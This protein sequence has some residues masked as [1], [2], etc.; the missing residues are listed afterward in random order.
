M[1]L[2]RSRAALDRAWTGEDRQ[3]VTLRDLL[4]HCS[5]LPA[6][7]RYFESR[8][9]PRL[10]RDGH[11]RGAA[12]VS[13]RARSRSTAIPDSCCS[14]SR[15]KM[16]PARRSIGSSMRG[17]I[18]SSGADVELRYRP[19]RRRGCERIAPTEDDAVPA[20]RGRGEV[21]DENA[22]ALGGVAAH[23]GLFGTAAAV[24]ACA[25]WWM[26]SPVAAA[27]RSEDRRVPGSSR[28]LGWDT[29]LPTS[30]C[31]TR[32]RRARS[33]TPASPARRCGSIPRRISMWCF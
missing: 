1:R 9:R 14:A 5:G 24:G 3:A 2:E 23:A 21:H 28:A 30:S 6:H 18:A 17:A 29:M 13:R 4:E 19:G 15:S 20:R 25:R 8:Q 27:V 10:V 31:G 32:C 12:R 26:R 16:P 33:A 11:L 7:R 22:A